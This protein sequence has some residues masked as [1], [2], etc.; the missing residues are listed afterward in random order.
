MAICPRRI[1]RKRAKGWRMPQ[2]TIYVGRP[3]RWGNHHHVETYGAGI[4]FE[5]YAKDLAQLPE[6]D[7]RTLLEPLRGHNLAC[8]CALGSPCHADVLLRL[9][10]ELCFT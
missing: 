8:W 4:A 6:A 10:N 9:A 1:Q 7:L 2:D 3:T 5:R